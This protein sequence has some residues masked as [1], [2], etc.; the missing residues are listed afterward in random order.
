[1]TFDSVDTPDTLNAPET[2]AVKA[3][4][5]FTNPLEENRY[6]VLRVEVTLTPERVDIA[7]TLNVATDRVVTVPSVDTML[8][9]VSLFVTDAPEIVASPQMFSV[10]FVSVPDTESV[11]AESVVITEFDE[12]KLIALTVFVILTF[13]KVE[14]PPTLKVI[15]LVVGAYSVVAERVPVTVVELSVKS[16]DTL[17][18]PDTLRL[19]SIESPDTL[20][21]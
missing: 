18:A 20:N 9:A 8:E 1:M 17:T 2:F 6:S 19:P 16:P 12:N 13:E 4:R 14:R 15:V 3:E 5:V 21:V 10:V 7:D 11:V